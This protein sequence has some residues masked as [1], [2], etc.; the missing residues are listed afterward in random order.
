MNPRRVFLQGSAAALA[1]ACLPAPA[2]DAYPSK[3]VNMLVP[4]PPGGV[5]DTVGRPVA[6]AMG[7][8]LGQTMIVENRGGAETVR[9]VVAGQPSNVDRSYAYAPPVLATV[10]G[11]GG[12]TRGGTRVSLAGTHFGV[13]RAAFSAT[14]DGRTCTVPADAPFSHTAT[15]CVLPPGEGT[16]ASVR[17]TVGGQPSNELPYRYAS[18]RIDGVLGQDGPTAGGSVVTLV[19]ENFGLGGTGFSARIGGQPCTTS[20]AGAGVA[21]DEVRCILPAGQGDAVPIEVTVAGQ[22]SNVSSYRYGA[23]RIDSIVGQGGSTEGAA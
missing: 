5:A 8:A 1:A 10:G 15:E 23:P 3:P 7:R 17:L 11:A 9:V 19:G 4:F 14:I 18:P 6:E 2:Q 21:H 16:A 22:P 13:D 20:G 12:P